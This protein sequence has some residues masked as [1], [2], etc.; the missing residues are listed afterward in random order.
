M[1]GHRPVVYVDF[2]ARVKKGKTPDVW[3]TGRHILPLQQLS[4]HNSITVC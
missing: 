4:I 2:D 1:T 3:I